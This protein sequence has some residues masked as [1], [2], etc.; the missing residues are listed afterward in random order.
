MLFLFDEPASNLHSAAQSLLLES[1]DELAHGANVIYTTH[2]HHLVNPRW[3][4]GC[5]VVKNAGLDYM[6]VDFD[7]NARNTDISIEPYRVFAVEHPNQS[8]YYQPILDVLEYRPAAIELVPEMV[9]LEGK[10]DYYALEFARYSWLSERS[11]SLLPGTGAGNLSNLISLYLGWAREF[12][13]LLDSDTEGS[14]QRNR[15]LELFGRTLEGRIFTLGD[16]RK[17]WQGKRM[18]DLFNK[19]DQLKIQQTYYSDAATYRKKTFNLT[20]LCRRRWPRGS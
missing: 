20:A 10:N 1:F 14:Q 8:H 15:Y 18:E 11:I 16:V 5:Y 3:L 12:V 13:V 6:D 9:M 17:S 7:F 19:N 2:S 4:G